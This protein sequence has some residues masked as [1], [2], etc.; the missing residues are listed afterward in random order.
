MPTSPDTSISPPT[1]R[2]RTRAEHH[3]Q[4]SGFFDLQQRVK[5]AGLLERRVGAYIFRMILLGLAFACAFTLLFTLG[6]TYWQLA[7]AV[8]FMLFFSQDAILSHDVTQHLHLDTIITN[9]TYS[10][11]YR[12]LLLSMCH[13]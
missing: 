8:L 1:P 12:S 10:H 4:V 7:V 2:R 9:A 5:D 13:T 3:A 11:L 6:D